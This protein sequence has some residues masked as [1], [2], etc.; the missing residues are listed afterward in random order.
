MKEV[1]TR[2]GAHVANAG[3]VSVLPTG[4][5]PLR[6]GRDGRDAD[7]PSFSSSVEHRGERRRR[8]TKFCVPVRPSVP[9]PK[10]SASKWSPGCAMRSE[11]WKKCFMAQLVVATNVSGITPGV[12]R[13]DA[14]PYWQS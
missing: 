14:T 12:E 2:T 11:F 5:E 9:S 6:S 4:A 1:M 3:F 7:F 8:N 13:C 10:A